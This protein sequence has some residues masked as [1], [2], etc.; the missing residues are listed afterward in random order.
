MTT[1]ELAALCE[2]R[3]NGLSRRRQAFEHSDA[4]EHVEGLI[5][6][7]RGAAS[8]WDTAV[9]RPPEG[10]P[11]ALRAGARTV[12]DGAPGLGAV[13]D[14]LESYA[15][16]LESWQARHG[17]GLAQLRAARQRAAGLTVAGDADADPHT[18]PER[19][20]AASSAAIAVLDVACAGYAACQDAYEAARDAEEALYAA[21][22]YVRVRPSGHRRD[23]SV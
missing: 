14:A 16:A 18:G 5:D 6:D 3:I 9:S 20:E 12:R 2:S 10:D 17:T 7:L 1:R 13:A 8:D 23:L 11:V 22:S 19:T 15:S 21:L 4:P